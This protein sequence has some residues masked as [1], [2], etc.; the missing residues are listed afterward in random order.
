[1]KRKPFFALLLGAFFVAFPDGVSAQG[2]VRFKGIRIGDGS[3]EFVASLVEQGFRETGRDDLTVRLRGPFLGYADCPV[4]LGC[5]PATGRIWGVGALVGGEAAWPELETVWMFV[6]G[7]F[8]E[9][10][11]SPVER[12]ESFAVAQDIPAMRPAYVRD[13][14]C[15]Y[16]AFWALPDGEAVLSVTSVE[17]LLWVR[18]DLVDDAL[19]TGMRVR[20]LDDI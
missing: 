6:V 20:I 11:G 5:D 12:T 19:R 7:V 13:G 3:D 16:R 18:V 4:E 8:A 9:K 10:Y 17:G 2:G 15:R 1:M 14:L